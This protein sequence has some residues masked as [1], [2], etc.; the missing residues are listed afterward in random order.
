MDA[1]VIEALRS[2]VGDAGIVRER[3]RR[4]PYESDG[5]A[6]LRHVPDLVLLPRNT[7]ET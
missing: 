2:I 6:L 4:I 3:A 5:L 1:R 7:A